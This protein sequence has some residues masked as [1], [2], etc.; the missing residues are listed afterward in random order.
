MVDEI[1]ATPSPRVRRK[2]QARKERILEVAMELLAAEGLERLTVVRLAEALDYTAGA[3]YRYFPSKDALLAEMQRHAVV[4]L[5]R[6]LAL[7]V[8]R[9]SELRT[10]LPAPL[11]RLV[12]LSH[13]YVELFDI[14]QSEMRLIN[15]LLADPRRLIGD[16]EAVH[17]APLLLNVFAG[18][19]ALF[20]AAAAAG[21]LRP[22]PVRDRTMALWTSLQGAS[23]LDKMRRFDP[24]GWNP[25]QVGQ[26]IYRALLCGWG[27]DPDAVDRAAR[28]LKTEVH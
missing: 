21:V 14:R 7:G 28:L 17:T 20:E 4:E 24:G 11:V 8:S 26:V 15:V 22:G 25:S 12:A 9:T 27:A 6:E 19:D 3:L 18:V 16:D 2:R 23:Q 1:A 13:A 10:D 5:G